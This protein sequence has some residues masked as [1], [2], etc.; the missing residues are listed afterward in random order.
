MAMLALLVLAAGGAWWALGRTS[1]DGAP[2]ADAA[3]SAGSGQGAPG[4]PGA[5]QNKGPGGNRPQPISA[6][7]AKRQDVNVTVPAIGTILYLYVPP[8]LA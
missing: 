4:S 6:M 2:K 5:G 7:A 1:G 8:C 3:A